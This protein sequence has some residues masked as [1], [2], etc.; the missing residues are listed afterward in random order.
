MAGVRRAWPVDETETRAQGRPRTTASDRSVRLLAMIEA[1]LVAG[2]YEGCGPREL[3][4][5]TW[6]PNEAVVDVFYA[7]GRIC[8]R[9]MDA[10]S[11]CV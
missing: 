6:A 9:G 8:A 5:R 10:S 1:A 2:G 3:P 11:R 7:H 4:R